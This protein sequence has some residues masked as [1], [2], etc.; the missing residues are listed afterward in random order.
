[1]SDETIQY[2][3]TDYLIEVDGGD[4][5]PAPIEYIV[6]L[7]QV[8]VQGIPGEKGEPGF[9]PTVSYILNND[10]FKINIVN[11]D[12]VTQ[13][14]NLYDYFADKNGYLKV[15]GSNADNP[16]NLNGL[17]I[18]TYA[19]NNV[20]LFS[21]TG[22]IYVTNGN[23]SV[24]LLGLGSGKAFIGHGLAQTGQL[25]L[26]SNYSNYT[27]DTVIEPYSNTNLVLNL[28]SSTKAYYTKGYNKAYTND[29]ELATIGDIGNG[30][31]TLTQGG[32]TKGT[33]TT[34]QS[35]NTTIDLDAGGG[36]ITNPLEI[37]GEPYGDYGTQQK[38]TIKAG[39]GNGSLNDIE[40]GLKPI[41][42]GGWITMSAYLI[43]QIDNPLS[44]SNATGLGRTLSL[45]YDSSILDLNASNELTVKGMVGADGVNAGSAGLVPAPTATDNTKFLRG[46]GTWQTVGG[47]SSYTA[48]TGIDITNDVI[49]VDNT[50]AMKTDIPSTSNFV[51]TNTA[52]TI[53]A[54][55]VFD[56][57][58][59]L[60]YDEIN[61]TN[62]NGI[63]YNE[64]IGIYVGDTGE[65]LLLQ[66]KD[67]HPYYN[68]NSLALSSEIPDVS[69]FVTNSSLATTLASYVQSSSLATV[70]TTGNYS[71]LN[72]RPNLNAYVT[73]D[74]T[75]TISG[76]KTFSS[77]THHTGVIT[78]DSAMLNPIIRGMSGASYRNMIYRMGNDSAIIVGNSNDTIDLKGSGTRPTYNTNSLALYSDIPSLTG[79]ATETWV[80]NQGYL[81]SSDISDMATQTWVGQQGYITGITSSDVTSALGYTPYNATNPNGF[82]SGIDSTMVVTALG[83]TPYAD[84]NPDGFISGISSTDVTNALGYTP[85]NSSN[86]NGYTSVVESTVSGW[87]FTKNVG[88]VTSVNNV[89]PDSNGNVTVTPTI[90]VID[91]GNA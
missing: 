66:G 12:G 59:I 85:Y 52:Q 3:T 38:I 9:T 25:S 90:T 10:T 36:S 53:T 1:M 82:I 74:T 87:G 13:T 71:D 26:A 37:I 46:D 7:G 83:Y 63:T 60:F 57:S 79:Y 70:A 75:Q 19:T 73:L 55:K 27:G 23:T 78:F 20:K 35:G 15:D 33:F 91:G 39:T 81:T 42:S 86:P 50:V 84:S 47:G 56:D 65:R 77:E 32:V 69:N 64:S 58:G 88:T 21:S 14:P 8:G 28:R 4:P 61:D 34:N 30:T 29:D 5:T 51:T 62:R 48:G 2:I 45:D 6:E 54:N 68:N 18:R 49:S 16:I 72:G 43:S 76:T 44:I 89:Q 40:L 31:I 11:Q 17:N 24:N 80:S 41:S 22:D 67:T